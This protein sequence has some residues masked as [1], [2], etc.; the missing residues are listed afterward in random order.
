MNTRRTIRN[1]DEVISEDSDDERYRERDDYERQ[2]ARD[3]EHHRRG[4]GT[5]DRPRTAAS[6]RV[7]GAE[8]LRLPSVAKK[9]GNT[10]PHTVTSGESPTKRHHTVLVDLDPGEGNPAPPARDRGTAT[11]DTRGDGHQHTSDRRRQ[12]DT[13]AICERRRLFD[14]ETL[15]HSEFIDHFMATAEATPQPELD[16]LIAHMEKEQLVASFQHMAL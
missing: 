2:R 10:E 8:S 11:S 12:A 1:W 13:R 15:E 9:R 6:R 4:S 14:D 16:G 3:E 5:R 7:T